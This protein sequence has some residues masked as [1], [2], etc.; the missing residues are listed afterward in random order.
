MIILS[1]I[2]IPTVYAQEFTPTS[3]ELTVYSEGSVKIVYAG[4]SDSSEAR[5]TVKFFGPPF[6][7]VAIRDEEDNPISYTAEGSNV[8]IDSLCVRTQY[9]ISDLHP[10]FKGR[11]SLDLKHHFT[12]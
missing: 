10:Y 7:N 9:S 1:L 3:L 4:E 12:H 6:N 8:T 2:L 11:C 5:V